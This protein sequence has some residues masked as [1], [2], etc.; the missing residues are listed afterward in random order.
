MKKY[1]LFFL[2]VTISSSYIQGQVVYQHVDYTT[3]YEFLDEMANLKHI[4]LNSAVKPYSRVMIAQKLEELNS[5][6][7]ELNKRQGQELDFYI[8][9]YRREISPT[10]TIDYATKKAFGKNR[11]KIADRS[12]RLNLFY[13]S[14]STFM[15]SFNPILGGQ[16][17]H[18]DSG[19]V[20]HRWNGA[21]MI[22]Y[23]GKSV[24]MYAS[25]RDNYLSRSINNPEFISKLTGGGFK[26][27]TYGFTNRDAVEYSEMRGGI[28]WNWKWGN[29]GLVKDHNVWGN[30]YNGANIFTNHAPSM[31]QVRLQMKPVKWIE[32]N[33]FHGWLSSKV[34]DS[35]KTQH[36]GTGTTTVF[37]PKYIAA[38]FITVRPVKNL[39]FSI[40]NSIIYSRS[41]N[42]GYVIPVMFYKSLDHTYSTLGN[43][44]LFYDLSIRNLKHFHFYST[45]FF[46]DLSIGRLFRS[47]KLNPWSIKGGVKVSD[48]IDNVSLTFEYTRNNVLTYKHYNPETTFETTKYNFGH[49]LRDNAQDIFAAISY[50]PLPRLFIEGSFN[51]ANKGPDYPDNRTEDDPVTGEPLILFYPFQSSII[52]EKTAYALQVRYE[53]VHDLIVMMK[54]EMADIRDETNTYTPSRF[55]GKQLTIQGMLT[56]GF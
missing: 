2:L 16:F 26:N 30:N 5:K 13:Y 15:L 39:Y 53:V 12:R 36:Y 44:Q 29:V 25:L 52:W 24:G 11:L 27:P 35:S 47:D 33:Y 50:A 40:G 46:D 43:S 1:L 32:L 22:F 17:W 54:A 37:V 34:T 18:N 51:L 9:G 7:A 48:L 4:E 45:G 23:A 19:L 31:S 28:T 3:I 38:N 6:K 56:F 21:E 55:Q 42:A 14:D 10:A 49:Y 8:K 20:Y 41:I